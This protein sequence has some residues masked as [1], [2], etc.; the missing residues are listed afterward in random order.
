MN[1]IDNQEIEN[2]N[3]NEEEGDD[4][5][6]DDEFGI[7]RPFNKDKPSPMLVKMK[8]QNKK[9][10]DLARAIFEGKNKSLKMLTEEAKIYGAKLKV[11]KAKKIH[12]IRSK[13][14]HKS[15]NNEHK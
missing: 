13:V 10:E 14:I 9:A 1:S 4:D 15:N 8:H 7:H 3:N 6:N 11:E 5:E 12:V 2:E